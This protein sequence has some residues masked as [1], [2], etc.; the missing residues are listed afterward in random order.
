MSYDEKGH[1][2]GDSVFNAD[3]WKLQ[4]TDG[5]EVIKYTREGGLSIA[6][7]G[8]LDAAKR[9]LSN[10]EFPM[11]WTDSDGF[12]TRADMIFVAYGN[13]VYV[14]A[15]G[16]TNQAWWTE[17]FKTFTACSVPNNMRFS[18]GCYND[19]G[20]FAQFRDGGGISADGKTW[21]AGSFLG[22]A[23]GG[24]VGT[25]PGVC[26]YKSSATAVRY[27]DAGGTGQYRSVV[28]LGG[29]YDSE[30]A[31]CFYGNGIFVFALFTG[32]R[33]YSLRFLISEDN[34]ET[35]R[36]IETQGKTP[37]R[38]WFDGE[39]FCYMY[40]ENGQYKV[41]WSADAQTWADSEPLPLVGD[42][43]GAFCG[44]AG[45]DGTTAV[46]IKYADKTIVYTT[47]D[48]ATWTGNEIDKS[49]NNACLGISG[50][51]NIAFTDNANA[52]GTTQDI[53]YSGGIPEFFSENAEYI[54]EIA[55]ESSL[56]RFVAEYEVTPFSDIAEAYLSGK[57][58]VCKRVV[59]GM[60]TY[61]T[62]RIVDGVIP[63]G[64]FHFKGWEDYETAYWVIADSN[65][66]WFID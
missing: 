45:S 59:G 27:Y 13:G 26:I 48:M 17:D 2:F 55:E 28:V 11:Q 21:E 10:V 35:W 22:V 33:T 50:G 23:I 60:E 25:G 32:S 9:D 66:G 5:E 47:T 38:W 19:N 4:N 7:G 24:L 40:H 46:V 44:G 1:L 52:D 65:R 36:K 43:A 53:Y 20:I 31:D 14:F 39:R 29:E 37:L 54:K 8:G 15:K 64:A 12:P 6:G 62:L 61:A 16:N 41:R 30:D 34:G 51:G 18:Y 42:S 63:N 49:T 3:Y 57:E 58:I 56:K